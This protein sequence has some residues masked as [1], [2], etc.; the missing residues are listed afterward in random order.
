M[1]ASE[2]VSM[3]SSTEPVSSGHYSGSADGT[4]WFRSH[5][6]QAAGEVID[7]LGGDGISLEGKRV[8]D[9]GCGDGITDLGL[10]VRAKPASLVGFDVVP[11]DTAALS[12]QAAAC[13]VQ[14][15]PDNL[16][17]VTCGETG[18]PAPDGSFDYV[19]SWSAFEHILDPVP[20]LRDIRRILTDEGVLFIQLWPFYD[21]AHGTH[22]VDWFPEGFAQFHYDDD[23]ILR[24]MRATGNQD[25]VAGMYEAYRTLNRITADGLHAALRKAGFRVVKLELQA[26]GAHIPHEAADIPPSRIGISGIK[27]LAVKDGPGP[28]ATSEPQPEAAAQPAPAAAGTTARVRHAAL[29]ISRGALRR[30]DDRLERL[31]MT[32]RD[33]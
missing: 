12:E 9:V 24:R 31:Q 21:S 8:A 13:D 19:L 29:R 7:F 27:L 26:D 11:T 18:L 10:A 3:Q 30:L 4:V 22:L 16:S 23:E 5:F 17:F 1:S 2:A 28:D 25:A 15:L 32:D 6:E 20:V 33:Q 14:E